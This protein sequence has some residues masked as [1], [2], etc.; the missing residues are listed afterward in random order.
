[1][2]PLYL[3]SILTCKSFERP[4]S[5]LYALNKADLPYLESKY[6][7]KCCLQSGD[8]TRTDL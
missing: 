4:F 2:L 7:F 5:N 3:F 6:Q 8:L 1:M